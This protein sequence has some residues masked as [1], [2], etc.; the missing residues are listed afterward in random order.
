MATWNNIKI[1]KKLIIAFGVGV[2]ANLIVAVC[3]FGL[4]GALKQTAFWTEHTYQVIGEMDEIIAGMVNQETGLRGYLVGGTENFLEPYHGGAAQTDKAIDE[5][6]KLTADNPTQQGR[7]GEVRKLVAQ[8]RGNHAEPTIKL[9]HDPASVEAA[10]QRE[11]SGAGKAGMDAIRAAVKTMRDAESSLMTVR[12]A[13]ANNTHQLALLVL[14]AGAAASAAIAL[15]MAFAFSRGVVNPVVAITA[16]LDR[17]IGG[18]ATAKIDIA[19]RDDEIGKLAATVR[20]FADLAEQ[21]QKAESAAAAAREAAERERVQREADKAREAAEDQFAIDE[22]GRGLKALADGNLTH[23]IDAEFAAKTR[24]LKDVFNAAIAKLRETMS[25]VT[26]NTQTIRSGTQ[27]IA[28]AS[29]DLSRRTEHQAATLE[30]T[31]AALD[32][33]TTTVRKSADGAKHANEVVATANQ[34]AENGSAVVRQAIDAMDGISKSSQQIGQI[35]GVIDEIAFQTNLLALNAGVEAARAG[36]AGRGFAVVAS[37]V[38]A[39]AQR[40]ADAAKE[41]KGLIS[42]SSAQVDSG[43]KLVAETGRVLERISEQV[44]EINRVVADIAAGAQEQATSLQQVNTAINLMDQATQQNATMVEE[45]TAAS[46]SLAR[47]TVQLTTLIEQFQVAA[48]SGPDIRRELQ[49][50]AP[51]AF[52]KP[53]GREAPRSPP[54][55]AR[56]PDKARSRSP[57]PQLKAAS[58]GGRAAANSDGWDEF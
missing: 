6:A 49:R 48:H 51:H 47:E 18:D 53:P 29:A 1:G 11:A 15:F 32:N 36:E 55:A 57:A 7:I 8:W 37:E 44:A 24:A 54:V 28:T 19:P 13:A 25:V 9:M 52:Q 27:E 33:I 38:R 39:L 30:E 35:I 31:A 40:S 23:R 58:G 14:L 12:A 46:D 41:I 2:V 50:V 34:A 4:F 26:N 17:I 21:K 45:S 20:T 43:V 42:N 56:A 10:R 16:A 3:I 22:I 5:V